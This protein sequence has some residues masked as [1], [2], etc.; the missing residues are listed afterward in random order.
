MR[1]TLAGTQALAYA[2]AAEDPSSSSQETSRPRRLKG[3]STGTGGPRPSA[4]GW[5]GRLWASWARLHRSQAGV[6]A[7]QAS[8]AR[9]LGWGGGSAPPSPSSPRLADKGAGGGGSGGGGRGMGRGGGAPRCHVTARSALNSGPA[10]PRPR[11]HP[12]A[13]RAPRPANR[14]SP[15]P[16]RVVCK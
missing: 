5:A 12:A 15:R 9:R 4:G 6:V 16:A 13:A 3:P 11:P 1:G 8:R 7:R 2:G 14:P 10:P